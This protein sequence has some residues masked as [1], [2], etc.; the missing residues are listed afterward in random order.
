MHLV[1][2]GS[3]IYTI[4]NVVTD[5]RKSN[6]LI[7]IRKNQRGFYCSISGNASL[8]LSLIVSTKIKQLVIQTI[9]FMMANVVMNLE[10]RFTLYKGACFGQQNAFSFVL[11]PRQNSNFLN[12]F[13]GSFSKETS[14]R[15]QSSSVYRIIAS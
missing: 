5:I 12:Q 14:F 10:L 11:N 13:S 9:V 3:R 6:K 7:A 4:K 1:Q 2:P 15:R 8:L